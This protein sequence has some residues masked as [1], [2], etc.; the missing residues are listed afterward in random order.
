MLT[1]AVNA[2]QRVGLMWFE[3]APV[4]AQ[5]PVPLVSVQDWSKDALCHENDAAARFGMH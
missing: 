1:P 4:G 2:D 5:T 3:K